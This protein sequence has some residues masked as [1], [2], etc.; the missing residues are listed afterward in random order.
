LTN[1]FLGARLALAPIVD[2][3]VPPAKLINLFT[4]IFAAV[5]SSC[6]SIMKSRDRWPG[7]I[8]GAYLSV[9]CE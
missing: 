1:L 6:M 2:I 4:G 7:L 5:E 8:P 9:S 3:T